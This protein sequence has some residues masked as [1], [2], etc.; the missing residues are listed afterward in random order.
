[1]VFITVCH[2][3][4]PARERNQLMNTRAAFGLGAPLINAIPLL[5]LVLIS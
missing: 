5:P 4:W 2:A 3:V 1:M